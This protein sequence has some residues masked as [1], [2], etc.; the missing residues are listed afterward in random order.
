MI[1]KLP[2]L[3]QST[4]LFKNFLTL[5]KDQL[6]YPDQTVSD[7]YV[8][9][10]SKESVAIIAL[11]SKGELLITHEYRHPTT[12][13]LLGCPGGLVDEGESVLHAAERELLEETGCT[14][15]TFESLGACY[16]LPGMLEQKMTVVLAKG[17]YQMQPPKHQ[18]QEV[19]DWEFMPQN[20]LQ[21]ALLS[22]RDVDAILCTAFLFY[23]LHS[24]L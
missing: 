5:R 21:E 23:R 19:I 2:T 14:A 8:L 6:L 7:Y 24:G 4:E 11:N 17:A 9:T 1:N 3:L 10:T 13:V 12:R 18:E 16:P 20:S 22:G 15:E